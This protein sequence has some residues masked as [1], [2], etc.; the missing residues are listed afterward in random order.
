[1]LELLLLT[2]FLIGFSEEL[3]FRGVLLR[4][5][6]SALSPLKAMMLSAPAFQCCTL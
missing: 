1:M 5:G 2:T 3:M 4:A 6:L